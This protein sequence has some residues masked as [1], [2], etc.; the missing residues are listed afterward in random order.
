[1]IDVTDMFRDICQRCTSSF[2]SRRSI[3]VGAVK[4]AAMIESIN[5]PIARCATTCSIAVR[6]AGARSS[7]VP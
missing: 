3:G 1:M 6:P 2:P 5:N 7:D 4:E